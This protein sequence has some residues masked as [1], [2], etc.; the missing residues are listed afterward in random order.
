MSLIH[1]ARGRIRMGLGINS[2]TSLY[3]GK[4]LK[5]FDFISRFSDNPDYD[6]KGL[7]IVS[8]NNPHLANPDQLHEI[9]FFS[10]RRPPFSGNE[11]LIGDYFV[12]SYCEHDMSMQ[13]I[14]MDSLQDIERLIT[15]PS[16]VSNKFTTRLIAIVNGKVQPYEVTCLDERTGKQIHFDKNRL[17]E[18]E[19]LFRQK[20]DNLQVKWLE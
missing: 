18:N 15:G 17:F 3:R 13:L 14:E 2:S 16:G 11:E 9:T 12:F 1:T 6:L 5:L 19:N 10:P 4:H 8:K 7:D 20:Y